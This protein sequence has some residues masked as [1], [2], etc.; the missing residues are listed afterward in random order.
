MEGTGKVSA[1]EF[2]TEYHGHKVNHLSKVLPSLRASCDSLIWT[3]GDSSLDNKYWFRDTAE[4]VGAY[5][6]A[7]EP[8][9]SKCDVTYWL[10]YLSFSMT[11]AESSHTISKEK[12]A[13]INTAVEATTLNQRSR[14]LLPQDVF[15]REN[16]KSNDVLIVSIGGN[17]VALFPTPCTILSMAGDFAY[18]RYV[19]KIHAPATHCRAMIIAVV[20]DHLCFL[21]LGH[22]HLVWA[23]SVTFLEFEFKIILRN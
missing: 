6:H 13:A 8:P 9:I 23:T 17:D 19:L 3:A 21:A 20:V 2:Y 7:L 11:K 5:Q 12:L 14:K 18:P 22:S 16:I 1:S 4:A 10:N 15:L